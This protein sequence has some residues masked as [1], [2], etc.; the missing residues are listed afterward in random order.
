M[1]LNKKSFPSFS[2]HF[3]CDSHSPKASPF[4]IRLEF[5]LVRCVAFSH[6]FYPRLPS[7]FSRDNGKRAQRRLLAL[8]CVATLGLFSS[9]SPQHRLPTAP[10]GVWD[11]HPHAHVS[12]RHCAASRGGESALL[13]RGLAAARALVLTRKRTSRPNQKCVAATP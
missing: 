3:Q 11:Y 8:S 4:R 7:Q 12:R 5:A 6:Q 9:L 13:L 10:S 1:H 2:P